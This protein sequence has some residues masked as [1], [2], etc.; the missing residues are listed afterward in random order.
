MDHQKKKNGKK[1]AMRIF[2][3]WV[4]GFVCVCLFTFFFNTRTFYNLK[5]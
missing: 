4:C 5:K 1:Y 3:W 2:G